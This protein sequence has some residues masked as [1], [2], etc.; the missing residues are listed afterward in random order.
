MICVEATM[1]YGCFFRKDL[2]LNATYFVA[3]FFC[4]YIFAKFKSLILYGIN[5]GV[6]LQKY[7][8][9]RTKISFF[10]FLL[11]FS[12]QN[13]VITCLFYDYSIKKR[14]SEVALKAYPYRLSTI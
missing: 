11:P 1:H 6:S 12:V 10:R 5:S 8:V 4:H 2:F 13:F 9:L 3:T 14:Y 7:A